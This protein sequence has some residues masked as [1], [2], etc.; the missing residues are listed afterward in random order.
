MASRAE[1]NNNHSNKVNTIVPSLLIVP[2]T[3][4]ISPSLSKVIVDN[5]D[6]NEVTT[7]NHFEHINK[8]IVS[9]YL[10]NEE[11]ENSYIDHHNTDITNDINVA[12]I[13]NTIANHTTDYISGSSNNNTSYVRTGLSPSE[14][15]SPN[16]NVIS[17]TYKDEN[18]KL[19]TSSFDEAT[20]QIIAK[21]SPTSTMKIYNSSTNNTLLGGNL[22]NKSLCYSSMNESV[23]SSNTVISPSISSTSVNI[24][25]SSIIT[26]ANKQNSPSIYRLDDNHIIEDHSLI[27]S[28]NNSQSN[29]NMYNENHKLN[30]I[31]T[32]ITTLVNNIHTQ[33]NH[34]PLL[35]NHELNKDDS[36]LW[37]LDALK[38][39]QSITDR[40]IASKELKILIKTASDAYWNKNYA[41][42][43]IYR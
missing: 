4:I 20:D 21:Y 39:T 18:N 19:F 28:T 17:Y 6:K 33:I 15:I 13:T 22:T 43:L 7:P 1:W 41:Q 24:I 23:N 3:S 27:T 29:I 14:N 31:N 40:I 11:Q 30:N 2:T 34:Q 8:K 32:N 10:S 36:I 35:I 37:L 38:P 5:R 12:N 16:S 9:P 26:A 42:V 25:K